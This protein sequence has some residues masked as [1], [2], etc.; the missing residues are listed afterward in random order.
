MPS[1]SGIK[2]EDVPN[3]IDGSATTAWVTPRY[4]GYANFGNLAPRKDG[5]GVVV[6]LGSVQDVNGIK[7]AMYRSGQ[8]AEVLAAD[9]N[10]SAPSSLS[11]FPQRLTKL[12]MVGSDL[13]ESLAKPV[14]TRYVLIHITELPSD[15]TSDGFR[16]GISE[17]SVLG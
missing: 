11:D 13:K 5:S 12:A 9:A 6:D 2:Q 8:K 15:G 7:I 16:G 10:A 1:G 17:I 3:A 4:R 14:R